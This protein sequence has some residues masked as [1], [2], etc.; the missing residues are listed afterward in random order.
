[1]AMGKYRNLKTLAVTFLFLLISILTVSHEAYPRNWDWDQNH[2]CVQGIPGKSGWC[3]WG[4]DGNP[5]NCDEPTQECCELFCK[6]CPVYANTGRLQKTFTDLTVPGVGPALTIIRTYNSQDWANTLFGYGWVFN[7]GKRLIISRNFVGDKI[8]SIRLETG[9]RNFYKE[10]PDGTLDRLTNY[11]ATYD[12]IKNVD[13]TYTILNRS[14]STVELRDD[15]KIAKIADRNQNE[16]VFTYDLVGCISRITNAS[17]KYVDFQLGPNGKIASISDNL[18]RTISY[19]YDQNGNLTSFTDPLGNTTQYIYNSDNLLTQIIDARGNIIESATYDNNQPPRVSTF[20]EKGETYTIAYFDGRT[21]KTDSQGNKWTYYFNDVGIIERVVDPLGNETKRQLNKITAQSV[22]WEEDANGNRTTYT[23]DA[24]GNIATKTDPLSNTWTYT[25]I[26]GTDLLET[27]TNPLGVVTK[28]AYDTNG[29]LTKVIRDFG[30]SL[31]NM[32]AYAYDSE[33]NQTSV[34]DPLGNTTI[35]EYDANGNLTKITDPLGNITTYTYHNMGNRVTE[36]DAL[37]NTTAYTYDLMNRKTSVTDPLGNRT[38]YSYDGSGNIVS[39]TDS[40]GNA[41]TFVYD[42]WNRLVQAVD[43]LGNGLTYTYDR[44]DNVLTMTDAN[45]NVTSYQYDVL[46]RRIRI[47]NALGHHTNLCYD[48][49]GNLLS[50]NDANGNTTTWSYDAANRM[51][52]KTYPDGAT[53][54]YTY[55]A[56]GNKATETDAKGD[57]TSFSYDRLNRLVTETYQDGTRATYTYDPLGRLL[58]GANADSTFAYAYD[59]LGRVTQSTQN[60]KTIKYSFDSVVNRISMTTPE[61]EIVQYTYN[62]ANQMARIQLSSG[63]G[64]SYNYDPLG[65]VIRKDHTGGS[66]STYAFDA[67][68]RL[69]QIRHLKS[70]GVVIYEQDNTFDSVGNITAKATRLGTA[71]YTYDAIYQLFF[72][73][74]PVLPT[75]T[76]TY[77]PVGNRLA[78]A[79]HS[80][81]FYNSRNQ[82]TGYDGKTFTY[83]ATG[84]TETVTDTSG[85]IQYSYDLKHR[86]VR[87]DF[88]GG[89]YVTYQYDVFGRRT[90]KNV[91]GNIVRYIWDGDLLFGEYDSSWNLL[92]NYLYATP[93]SNVSAILEGGS[94][95]YVLDNHLST[96]QRIIDETGSTKWAA[97]FSSFGSIDITVEDITC[98]L[99]F[100]GQYSDAESGL[101]Y[102]YHRYYDPVGGTYTSEDPLGIEG[103]VNLYT[104]VSN[105]PIMLTDPLG[106]ACGAGVTDYLVPDKPLWLYDFTQACEYHDCCWACQKVSKE[107]CDKEF[108]EDMKSVCRAL[109]LVLRP[110]CYS[111]AWVYYKAV[112]TVGKLFYKKNMYYCCNNCEGGTYR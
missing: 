11:G 112:A 40:M 26:A 97:S 76:F 69:N 91:N 10:Y 20:T 105:N 17:G 46:G 6:I 64:I 54:V 109:P 18:G 87:I 75:E 71:T 110:L 29:N 94:L 22:D 3:R 41:T 36:T 15:G 43:P 23:Y 103:G 86:L 47:T 78:S 90:Q 14:G 50:L 21:E 101:Y 57:T 27:E 55:N 19:G 8:L 44:D 82:L 92:R 107:Q 9:E 39:S 70:N 49:N 89:S 85:T 1:M 93:D 42:A 38:A 65:R 66:Y 99:R 100:P 48:A 73:N 52:Q 7:F 45:G 5:A 83:D 111:D 37:G 24:D 79:D 67:G 12:L 68:G 84:N 34:T 51:I 60:G 106:L 35:Y 80:S 108:Y 33:G 62:S 72:A 58:T 53:V 4:Y 56:L 13:G 104:Y 88:P 30:G 96:P 81:W 16:L 102:N 25:Y 74:H 31:E 28:Y 61:D 95:Y 98:D 32:T 77:D 63:K 59:A 2:D